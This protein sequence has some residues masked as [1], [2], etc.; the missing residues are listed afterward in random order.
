MIYIE[1]SAKT[2]VGIQQ[3]FE[4][5]PS[6]NFAQVHRISSEGRYQLKLSNKQDFGY[7]K[8]MGGKEKLWVH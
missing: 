7:S 3:T 2:K 5:K 4:G 6:K 1:C 8:L